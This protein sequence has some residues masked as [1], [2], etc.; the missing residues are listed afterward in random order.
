M[1]VLP[2][3]AHRR[4]RNRLLSIA[5]SFAGALSRSLW[6]GEIFSVYVYLL[7]GSS[8]RSA[9]RIGAALG[10]LGAALVSLAAH[11]ESV[12]LLCVSQLVWGAHWAAANPSADALFADSIDAGGRSVWFTTKYQMIQ[13]TATTPAQRLLFCV[14]A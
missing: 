14:L 4:R 11:L 5:A 6:S 1:D 8:T 10:A 9:L 7:T 13:T 12:P 2:D 3:F